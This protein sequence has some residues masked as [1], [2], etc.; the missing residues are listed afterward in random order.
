MS[1]DESYFEKQAKAEEEKLKQ[2]VS[3]LSEED[4]KLIYEK[5]KSKRHKVKTARYYLLQ[6]WSFHADGEVVYG[7]IQQWDMFSDVANLTLH[8]RM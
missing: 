1:P 3:A 8:C 6:T 7:I 5:G 2:K 4:K